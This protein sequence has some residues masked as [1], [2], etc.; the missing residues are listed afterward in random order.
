M[1]RRAGELYA[2]VLLAGVACF[3]MGQAAPEPRP[4]GSAPTVQEKATEPT[5]AVKPAGLTRPQLPW[6]HYRVVAQR[7]IF[8]RRSSGSSSGG[9]TTRPSTT[10]STQTAKPAAASWVLTGIVVQ[11]SSRLA[12]FENTKTSQTLRVQA[13]Q[14]VDE[15]VI[16]QIQPD[17][18]ILGKADVRREV[19]VGQSMDGSET[20]LG[21]ASGDSIFGSSDGAATSG[22]NGAA[23]SGS[24]PEEQSII[25]RMRARR[26]REGGR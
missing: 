7:N 17:R 23:K 18:V 3:L 19:R 9:E 15:M 8:T 6:S 14:Q 21:E 1:K 24:S 4:A 11:G 22:A 25:E 12:F 5:A 16:Q 26:A 20:S 10:E 2:I 13:G